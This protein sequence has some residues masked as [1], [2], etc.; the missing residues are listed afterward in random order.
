[1]KGTIKLG[2]NT[3]G[4]L[5]NLKALGYDAQINAAGDIECEVQGFVSHLDLT[6]GPEQLMDLIG[7]QKALTYSSKVKLFDEKSGEVKEFNGV[8]M[9]L[10]LGGFS[11]KMGLPNLS[12]LVM[13]SGEGKKAAPAAQVPKEW[14]GLA[15][16]LQKTAVKQASAPIK[17][18][19][20]ITKEEDAD[21]AV[22]RIDAE[23]E[24]AEWENFHDI[25]SGD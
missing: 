11:K 14:A 2:Q 9:C 17:A 10:K 8:P 22:D 6:S 24:T 1:M 23:E 20:V 5:N 12:C 25:E 7:E 15:A 4:H 21:E 3:K 18:A 16:L 13:K 19:P